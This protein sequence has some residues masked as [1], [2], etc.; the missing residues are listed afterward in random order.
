MNNFTVG[1]LGSTSRNL[2]N[3]ITTSFI[4]EFTN[5]STRGDNQ[6]VF[7]KG[8]SRAGFILLVNVY[9]GKR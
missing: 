4:V 3:Q 8:F 9:I 5:K 2:R 1:F 6:H 7:R